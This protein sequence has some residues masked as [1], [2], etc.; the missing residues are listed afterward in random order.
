MF[1]Y[2]I[3]SYLRS[4]RE[5]FSCIIVEKKEKKR[6]EKRDHSYRMS[7]INENCDSSFN[8]KNHATS[9]LRVREVLVMI[10]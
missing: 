10:L 1:Y 8:C 5:M 2:L 7:L 6:K 9:I 3:S 4:N